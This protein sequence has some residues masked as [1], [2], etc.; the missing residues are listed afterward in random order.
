MTHGRRKWRGRGCSDGRSRPE[1]GTDP[2]TTISNTKH[3]FSLNGIPTA[4]QASSVS[5]DTPLLLAHF[6][7]ARQRLTMTTNPHTQIPRL[8]RRWRRTRRRREHS[9]AARS[10]GTRIPLTRLGTGTISPGK[11]VPDA[12]ISGRHGSCNYC[13]RIVFLASSFFLPAACLFQSAFSF[14]F[15][16]RMRRV[17]VV[18]GDGEEKSVPGWPR[19]RKE[20]ERGRE[21]EIGHWDRGTGNRDGNGRGGNERQRYQSEGKDKL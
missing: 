15:S 5:S 9:P 18:G 4:W 1:R 11:K 19:T 2:P 8:E 14:A 7:N 21:T 16:P 10:V 6:N 3:H 12:W 20:R 17:V 13:S